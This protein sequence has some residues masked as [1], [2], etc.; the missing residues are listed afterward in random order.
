M[1]NLIANANAMAQLVL[2]LL[3]NRLKK[4]PFMVLF[5][6]FGPFLMHNDRSA[7]LFFLSLLRIAIPLPTAFDRIHS[8]DVADVADPQY[9]GKQVA[10]KC[11]AASSSSFP[12]SA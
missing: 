9:G 5:G 2:P 7:R 11:Q 6:M 10:A 8:A 4:V 1:K 12:R 3:T